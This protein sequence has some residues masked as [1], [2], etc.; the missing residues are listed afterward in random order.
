MGSNASKVALYVG[1]PFFGYPFKPFLNHMDG[2]PYERAYAHFRRDHDDARNLAYH[3]LCLVFQLTY[4]FGFLKELDDATVGAKRPVL[5][6]STALLWTGALAADSSAP[7]PVTVCSALSLYLAFSAR[8]KIQDNWK[9]LMYLQSVLEVLALQVFVINKNKITEAHAPA[10]DV[11]QFGML[12]VARLALQKFVL[13]PAQGALKNVRTP[14]NVALAVFMLK[15]CQDPFGGKVPPFFL[16][17]VGYVIAMLTDQRW[18]FFYAGGF[19]GSLGQG[20]SH[21]YSMQLATMPQLALYADEVAHATFFPSLL[22]HSVY[23]S[24]MGP[25][26]ANATLDR[27][28]A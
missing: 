9:I 2:A 26:G 3:F 25:G 15:A 5:A 4:N 6:L 7:V 17:I 11:A 13:T 27:P 16:G 18:L 21:H 23:E 24:L 22:Y 8:K 19:L 1:A 28:V 20:V 10:F 12:L 14:I